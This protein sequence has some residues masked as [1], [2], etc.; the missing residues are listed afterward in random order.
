MTPFASFA[1]PGPTLNPLRDNK[2]F[3]TGCGCSVWNKKGQTLVFSDLEEKAPATV[4]VDGQLEKLAWSK[5][6]KR[7]LD[8]VKGE[9]FSQV[10]IKGAVRLQ[11]D[12]KTT[13]VCGKK[14]ESCEVTKYDVN[15]S[16]SDGPRRTRLPNL[17][18]DCGC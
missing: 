1:A 9:R 7:G 3:E 6:T 4:R 15:A 10:Y 17:K 14:D 12:Y 11:L 8:P 2:D 13:F 5:S 18:G 16:L